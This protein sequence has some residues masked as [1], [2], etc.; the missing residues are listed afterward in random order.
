MRRTPHPQASVDWFLIQGKVCSSFAENQGQRLLSPGMR[1][2]VVGTCRSQT[3]A[4]L[5]KQLESGDR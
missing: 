1:F 4:S 2:A 3:C 5:R